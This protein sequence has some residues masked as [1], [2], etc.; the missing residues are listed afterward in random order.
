MN[1]SARQDNMD[2]LINSGS[3]QYLPQ[4]FVETYDPKDW[5]ISEEDYA[6]LLAGPDD[7]WYWDAWND[8]ESYA[9]YE[10]EFGHVWKLYHNED[11]WA[12]RDGFNPEDDNEDDGVSYE[13]G[14]E[15]IE[16]REFE[17]LGEE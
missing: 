17:Y 8:V 16:P 2:I 5:G 15:N 11:L 9:S 7:E 10:D 14:D 4:E 3:G 6:T 1:E 12:I 13:D